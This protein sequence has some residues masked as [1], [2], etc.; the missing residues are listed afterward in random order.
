MLLLGESS[1]ERNKEGFSM[2]IWNLAM[3]DN[4]M[5]EIISNME[6]ILLPLL[7]NDD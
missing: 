4:F 6:K 5:K 2:Q 1:I 3:H 7:R